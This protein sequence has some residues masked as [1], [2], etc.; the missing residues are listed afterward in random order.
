[1]ETRRLAPSGLVALAWTALA[2]SSSGS[3][4]DARDA[5]GDRSA[6]RAEA[7]Q[8]ADVAAP[9]AA[10]E[11]PAHRPVTD[12]LIAQLRVPPGFRLSVFA[13]DLTNPRMMAVGP[14]GSVYV[15]SPMNSEV[16]R[17]IDRN[18]DGD[19]ADSGEKTVVLMRTDAAF[20]GVHGIAVAGDKMYLAAV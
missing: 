20:T 6:D 9:D 17:L 5:A 15:T 4:V 2:C 3:G 14:D 11:G 7:A 19:T 8:P 16:T 13:R 1:M 12:A 18:R 10:A